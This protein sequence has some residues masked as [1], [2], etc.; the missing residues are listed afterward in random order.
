MSSNE[1]FPF[2]RIYR[3]PAKAYTAY[4]AVQG[5]VTSQLAIL[6]DVRK[7][8]M[9]RRNNKQP[10]HAV[11]RRK[12]QRRRQ[13]NGYLRPIRI[14][15]RS[16][17]EWSRTKGTSGKWSFSIKLNDLIKNFVSTYDEFKVLK[18][19]VRW[20]PNNSTNSQGL[21]SAVLMDQDGFG[22]FGSA[23]AASWFNTICSMP[24]SYV[25]NRHTSFALRWK[26]TEPT[27]RDWRSYQRG[28]T[29]YTVCHFYMADN[30]EE[31]SELGGIIL[32]TGLAQGRGMYY[33]ASHI[34]REH[35]LKCLANEFEMI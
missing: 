33:N 13:T 26:P 29:S 25:G 24:G 30:G 22:E 21:T 8:I 15:V 20:L 11:R 2:N 32:I 35:S 28:E 3:G 7:H 34:A 16:T 18:L 19:I 6:N 23:S 31:D 9:P 27:A 14:P 12:P 4:K 1:K 17:I 5:D 10:G